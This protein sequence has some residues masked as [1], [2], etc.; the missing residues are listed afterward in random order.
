MLNSSLEYSGSSIELVGEGE[1]HNPDSRL[2]PLVWLEVVESFDEDVW[3][4]DIEA[5]GEFNVVS[6]MG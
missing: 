5:D 4:F 1:S 3:W 6:N 2:L